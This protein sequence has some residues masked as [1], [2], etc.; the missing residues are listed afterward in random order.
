QALPGS[1]A[2]VELESNGGLVENNVF[3]AN[4]GEGLGLWES[5][6]VEV[7]GNEFRGGGVQ[8]FFRQ[9]CCEPRTIPHN[10][11]IHHNRFLDWNQA[12]MYAFNDG[13]KPAPG[14]PRSVGTKI[15]FNTYRRGSGPFL[16]WLGNEAHSL[17]DMRNFWGYELNGTLV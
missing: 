1:G 6:N 14:D 7:R 9:V 17:Q 10:A 13:Y 4:E 5:H 15:D 16:H 8:L 2:W 11:N 3:E 12:A